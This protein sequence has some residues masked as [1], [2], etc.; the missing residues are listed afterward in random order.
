MEFKRGEDNLEEVEKF[1]YLVDT[2]SFLKCYGGA[3]ETVRARIGRTWKKFKELSVVLVRKQGL[4]FKLRGKIYQCFVIPGL[5]YYCKM[6]EFAITDEARLSGVEPP[7]IRMCGWRPI[8]RVSTDVLWD[9]VDVVK[10]EDI[11]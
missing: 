1:C 11:F 4:S 3:S 8:D 5:L 10:I 9:S 2:I 6:W 7:M